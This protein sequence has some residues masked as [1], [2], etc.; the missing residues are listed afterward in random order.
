MLKLLKQAVCKHQALT[1]DQVER[2]YGFGRM[3]MQK[4]LG[5]TECVKCGKLVKIRR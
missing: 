5:L 3:L 2:M 4:Q 1:P